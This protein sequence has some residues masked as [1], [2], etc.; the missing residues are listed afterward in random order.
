MKCVY[1]L[2][3]ISTSVLVVIVCAL[4]ALCGQDSL[5]PSR[6]TVSVHWGGW[7]NVSSKYSG[8]AQTDAFEVAQGMQAQGT[9]NDVGHSP[10]FK[11]MNTYRLY[12]NAAGETL[13]VLR[14]SRMATVYSVFF[15]RTQ[16]FIQSDLSL[17][18][19]KTSVSHAPW[20]LMPH[21]NSYT[22]INMLK[23]TQT[24]TVLSNVWLPGLVGQQ[25][26]HTLCIIVFGQHMIDFPTFFVFVCMQ[27][28]MHVCVSMYVVVL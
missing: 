24:H 26:P 15:S 3:C 6:M 8:Y 16:A 28:C 23:H 19:N 27:V 1:C 14:L 5:L 21:T 2:S 22:H 18:G 7:F 11:S 4:Q 10:A 17:Q 12:F 20:L 9:V 13:T 25:A